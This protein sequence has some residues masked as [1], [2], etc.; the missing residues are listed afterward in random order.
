V[1]SQTKKNIGA[2]SFDISAEA[3]MRSHAMVARPYFGN[4][5][6]HC[7]TVDIIEVQRAGPEQEESTFAD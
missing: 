2:S 5:S 7:S 4:R 1:S 3:R 6:S